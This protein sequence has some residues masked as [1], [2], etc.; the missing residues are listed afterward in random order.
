[1][2]T[3]VNENLRHAAAH[4]ADRLYDLQQSWSMLAE[5][6]LDGAVDRALLR[7]YYLD[8]MRAMRAVEGL[9]PEPADNVTQTLLDLTRH[10]LNEADRAHRASGGGPLT[11]HI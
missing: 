9:M 1:M 5:Q 7:G 8:V 11:D 2:A 10:C 3:V 4:L 6:S